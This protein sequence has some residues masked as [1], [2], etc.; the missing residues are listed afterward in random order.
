M[1]E[2][3]TVP[4]PLRIEQLGPFKLKPT[5]RTSRL[6]QPAQVVKTKGAFDAGGDRRPINQVGRGFRGCFVHVPARFPS[7][8]GSTSRWPLSNFTTNCCWS[9]CS[10][11]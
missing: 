7:A 2:E 11:A 5:L 3:I 9:S 4:L 8:L 10:T 1:I 6:D